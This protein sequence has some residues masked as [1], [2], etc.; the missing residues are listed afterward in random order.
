MPRHPPIERPSVPPNR[1]R[2][3]ARVRRAED[4]CGFRRG[5]REHDRVA[6][7][8]RRDVRGGGRVESREEGGRRRGVERERE[9][10]A[11]NTSNI[12]MR[13]RFGSNSLVMRFVVR[14]LVDVAHS[15]PARRLRLSRLST[16]RSSAPREEG[17]RGGRRRGGGGAGARPLKA[18]ERRRG[19]ARGSEPFE[20]RRPPSSSNMVLVCVV[21]RGEAF[22]ET[23]EGFYVCLRCGTQSQ[24]VV[25]ET[26]D[27]DAAIEAIRGAG[28]GRPQPEGSP[29]RARDR[30]ARAPPPFVAAARRRDD[31][32]DDDAGDA[33]EARDVLRRH[34][35]APARAVRRAAFDVRLPGGDVRRRRGVLVPVRP[36]VRRHGARLRRPE[37]VPG[38]LARE[39]E[40]ED[41]DED[42]DGASEG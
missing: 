36:R 9:R 15:R 29:A 1:R 23:N 35:P 22:D 11:R 28:R 14:P 34:A 10:D 41:E 33:R 13:L 7:G 16:R 8:R 31:A 39:V 21:C 5:A 30:S 18:K 37:D 4:G 20:R 27:D 25:R 32:G 42:E 6:G 2:R 17:P 12:S 38:V 40:A 24:D 19:A 3:G 26:Q